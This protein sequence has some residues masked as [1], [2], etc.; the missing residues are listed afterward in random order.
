[1]LR[2]ESREQ[3]CREQRCRDAGISEGL[4]DRDVQM[5]SGFSVCDGQRE[6]ETNRETHKLRNKVRGTQAI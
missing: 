6:R 4:R 3:R 2:A 1:M 5:S